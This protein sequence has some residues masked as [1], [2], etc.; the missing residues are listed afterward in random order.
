VS[1]IDSV[2]LQV[3]VWAAGCSREDGDRLRIDGGSPAVS[4]LINLSGVAGR[5]PLIASG[6]SSAAKP[7]AG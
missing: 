3:L 7:L 2:G 5:L 1:F 6:N 4:Q